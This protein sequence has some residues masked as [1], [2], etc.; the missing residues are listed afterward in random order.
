MFSSIGDET[1]R[2]LW[3]NIDRDSSQALLSS[4]NGTVGTLSL[5]QDIVRSA[6]GQSAAGSW[7][8]H[9]EGVPPGIAIRRAGSDVTIGVLSLS[10]AG[11]GTLT[12]AGAG[13]YRLATS[14]WPR[15]MWR[16]SKD[17]RPVVSFTRTLDGIAVTIEDPAEASGVLSVL[18]LLGCY[19]DLSA[20]DGTALLGALGGLL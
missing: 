14:G 19:L 5:D 11:R 20:D 13:D 6:Y 7:S 3:W 16:F 18:C 15:K 8:F 9:R 4:P 17:G 12:L 10:W 2:D 1:E